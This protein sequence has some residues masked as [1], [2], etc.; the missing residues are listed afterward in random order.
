MRCQGYGPL[1]L[2][3]PGAP[4]ASNAQAARCGAMA[5]LGDSRTPEN[6]RMPYCV[7]QEGYREIAM[8]LTRKQF[9]DGKLFGSQDHLIVWNSTD[10]REEVRMQEPFLWSWDASFYERSKVACAWM[11]RWEERGRTHSWA[12]PKLFQVVPCLGER[13]TST[14][15]KGIAWHSNALLL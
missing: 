15:S 1:F 7:R 4:I 5:E 8:K 14:G 13:R 6:F 2:C 3:F 11:K 9:S 12:D 10:S